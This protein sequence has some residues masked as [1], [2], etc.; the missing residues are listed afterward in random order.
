MNYNTR[1]K[2]IN[3]RKIEIRS[4]LESNQEVDLDAIKTEL[5]ALENE[6][7]EIRSKLETLETIKVN[8]IPTEQSKQTEERNMEFNTASL[9]YR[10]AFMNFAKTGKMEYRDG[11]TD[12]VTPATPTTTNVYSVTGENAAVIPATTLNLIVE[13]M[14]KY[15]EIYP[16][17]RK[18]SYPAGIVVPTSTLAGTANWIGEGDAIEI[19]KKATGKITFS[20]YQLACALGITFLAQVQS[21]EIFEAAL[22]ENVARNMIKKLEAAIVNGDGNGKPTGILQATPHTSVKLALT[23]AGIINVLKAQDPAYTNSKLFVSD[24]TFYD[25][26]GIV[27][28]NKQ[29]IARVNSGIAAGFGREILG[30]EI[31]T[32]AQL[33]AYA[34]ASTND[35]IGFLFDPQAYV[36]NTAYQMDMVTYVEPETRNKVYQSV[37]VYDGKVVD[38]NSLVLITK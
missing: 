29:P 16:L 24:S 32:T 2:D 34:D 13:K 4:A 27:D 14:E 36:L 33:P 28:S 22:A 12:P 11:E 21:L 23:Y 8:D 26:M 3:D 37:G 18:M 7:K 10:K 1:L 6:E 38:S 31:I 9:E 30:K 19:G 25:I 35:V 5:D 17:V 15:G 20:A